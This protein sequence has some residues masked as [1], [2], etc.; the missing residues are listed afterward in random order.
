MTDIWQGELVAEAV[1]DTDI[2]GEYPNTPENKEINGLVRLTIQEPLIISR[3]N[4]AGLLVVKLSFE[5]EI[6]RE[7]AEILSVTCSADLEPLGC[8]NKNLLIDIYPRS[9]SG[10]HNPAET[11]IKIAPEVE[12]AGI[13]VAL[14]EIAQKHAPR[15]IA[16]TTGFFGEPDRLQPHWKLYPDQLKIEGI[17]DFFVLLSKPEGCEGIKLRLMAEGVIKFYHWKYRL[18]APMNVA[19]YFPI[20]VVR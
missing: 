5:F 13:K 2:R 9:I 19:N 11:G 10:T 14:G 18:R 6:L 16:K 7:N 4:N 20:Y 12:I 17:E 1:D 3:D 15:I 8:R